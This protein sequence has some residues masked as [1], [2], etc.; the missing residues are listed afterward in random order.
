MTTTMN[1]CGVVVVVAGEPMNPCFDGDDDDD[2]DYYLTMLL[3]STQ[4]IQMKMMQTR[5]MM[6][7]LPTAFGSLA[8]C[9]RT[10]KSSTLTSTV[11]NYFCNYLENV[12]PPRSIRPDYLKRLNCWPLPPPSLTSPLP[13]RRRLHHCVHCVFRPNC[14]LASQ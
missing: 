13:L 1:L 14:R 2:D 4:T 6:D 3:R 7:P 12:H 8:L 5:T 11:P 10:V 9:K